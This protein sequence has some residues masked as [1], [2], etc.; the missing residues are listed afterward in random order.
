MTPEGA[1]PD[2]PAIQSLEV[3]L[4]RLKDRRRELA[5]DLAVGLG[6]DEVLIPSAMQ[7]LAAIET[8][9]Q[10]VAAEVGEG[11]PVPAAG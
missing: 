1:P 10:A 2:S 5:I 8:A 7:P 3:L 11:D 4:W 6:P 9:I